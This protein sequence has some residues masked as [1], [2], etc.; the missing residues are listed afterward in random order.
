M[1]A[2]M[3]PLIEL[4]SQRR[5]LS[6]AQSAELFSA[7]LSGQFNDD[8]V[9][10][11]L[12]AWAAKGETADELVGAAGVL[13][14]CVIPIAC[15]APD[16]I[17][18]CGTGGDGIST[19][20]VSTAAAIVAAAAGA[21]VAKHGNRSNSRRS[22]SAEVLAELGVDIEAPP[23]TV[24]RCLRE[25]RIGFLFAPRLHA[26][27]VRVADIRRKIGRPTIF[28]LLGPLTNPAGVKRQII[29]VPRPELLHKIAQALRELGAIHAVVVHGHDG[30]CDF[31]ITGES[32]FVELQGGVIVDRGVTPEQLGLRRASLDEL[33]VDGPAQSAAVIRAIFD[34]ERSARRDHVLLNAAAAL[35]V[36]GVVSGL[37]DG[38]DRAAQAI[39]SGA[40]RATL[41]RLAVESRWRDETRAAGAIS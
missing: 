35:V 8:R 14:R 9:E 15:N 6:K 17:D 4:I 31:S 13:R 30:L 26:A 41:E 21:V 34:G 5:G 22:G 33:R 18:T 29:G 25:V 12:L 19:F 1:P 36:A 28:N 3:E 11:L 2:N 23:P 39:D 20:N 38:V 27:M 32:R 24:E 10:R 7:L 16:A 37:A 40:A